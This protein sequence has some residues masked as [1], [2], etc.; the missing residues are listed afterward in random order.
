M[1]AL[2]SMEMRVHTFIASS[3]NCFLST[4]IIY[5]VN[6]IFI[7]ELSFRQKFE[8]FNPKKKGRKSIFK[9]NV[10]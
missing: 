6:L 3:K 10:L 8:L 4:Q 2:A 1:L 9:I 7:H 5:N